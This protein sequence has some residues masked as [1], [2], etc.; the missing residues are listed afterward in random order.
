MLFY[1]YQPYV[2]N[3]TY[4]YFR[5]SVTKVSAPSWGEA[6]RCLVYPLLKACDILTQFDFNIVVVHDKNL[7]VCYHE[8]GDRWGHFLKLYLIE[9]RIPIQFDYVSFIKD[10]APSIKE[11]VN[12]VRE[13]LGVEWHTASYIEWHPHGHGKF[14]MASWFGG[15]RLV[16]PIGGLDDAELRRFL[17][18]VAYNALPPML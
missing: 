10:I 17:A 12:T 4:L 7:F 8:L 16:I 6:I 14:I 13:C 5:G 11:L 18:E 2:E 3:S 15:E 1:D 9:E